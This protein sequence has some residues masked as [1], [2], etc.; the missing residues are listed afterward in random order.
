MSG[1]LGSDDGDAQDVGASNAEV[2]AKAESTPV[3]PKAYYT[4]F[5]LGVVI[6]FTVLDRQILALM[7]EPIKQDYG[8]SDTQAALLL[9]AAFSLTYAVAGLPIA[10]IADS[11]NRRN[12]IAI[13]TAF[14]SLMTVACGLAQNYTHLFLARMGIG[15]GEAGYGPATWSMVTD[16]FPREKVAM[17]TGTLAIGAQL[18]M[19]LALVIGGGAYA[20]VA[21]L[22]PIDVPLI[23]EI[24]A[25]HWP[26]IIV[27]FP[28]VLWAMVVWAT[29]DEP[30]RTG[31]K[32]LVG[33]KRTAIPVK[34]VARYMASDWRAYTAIIG[35]SCLAALFSLGSLQWMPTLF[36]REYGW[37]LT[38]VGLVQGILT[39]IVGP[40][41][42]LAGGKISEIVTLRGVPGANLRIVLAATMITVP[43]AITFPLIPNP[44]VMLSVYGITIFVAG[45][46]G[47]P[48]I[49]AMQL[50]TPN[51]MRAQV[52]AVSLFSANVI[53]FA[54]G[55][56]IVALFTDY[57]FSDPRDLKYSMSLA[58]AVLGPPAILIVWQGIKPYARSY[59]R[60]AGGFAD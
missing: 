15:I 56:L 1:V 25:W 7:I 26:F 10:R 53:A 13:C 36:I 14:W 16:I 9:G 30:K 49:A 33:R 60:T 31:E 59:E 35:G 2:P 24:K 48:G 4:L 28:G 5:V 57:L 3:P 51:R 40:L 21:H 18:G 43:L 38:K 32:L 39:M 52:G 19:G 54:L 34:E 47:G 17:A 46:K 27:G 50:I 44:W 11:T 22:P 41:G 12:L 8:I 20:L 55:P 23:G 29:I 37:S 58:A 6:L 42:L 45:V